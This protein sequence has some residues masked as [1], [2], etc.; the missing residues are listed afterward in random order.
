L[1]PRF[2]LLK[3]PGVQQNCWLAGWLVAALVSGF[4]DE[5]ET[6]MGANANLASIIICV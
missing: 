5:E 1:D 3:L 4:E 2:K 6:Y